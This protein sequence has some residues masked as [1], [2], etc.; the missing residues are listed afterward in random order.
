MADESKGDAPRTLLTSR[1]NEALQYAITAHG[2]QTRKCTGV[3]Y[4]AHLPGV[5]TST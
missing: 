3:I 5:A 4:V 1:F 2:G